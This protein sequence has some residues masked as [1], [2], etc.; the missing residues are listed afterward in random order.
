MTHLTKGIGPLLRLA[1]L[2]LASLSWAATAQAAEVDAAA[3]QALKTGTHLVDRSGQ[4]AR[5]GSHTALSRWCALHFTVLEPRDGG[6]CW[7]WSNSLE[8]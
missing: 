3:M 2:S 8:F 5:I 7:Y 6:G 4:Q 1:G